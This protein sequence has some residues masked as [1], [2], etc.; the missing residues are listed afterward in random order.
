MA[1]GPGRRP[2]LAQDVGWNLPVYQPRETTP[3]IPHGAQRYQRRVYLAVNNWSGADWLICSD[4]SVTLEADSERVTVEIGPQ[5]LLLAYG[6]GAR[7]LIDRFGS[8]VTIRP[9][10]WDKGIAIVD[11]LGRRPRPGANRCA[12][13]PRVRADRHLARRAAEPPRHGRCCSAGQ[14]LTSQ[15]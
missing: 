7:V 6:D 11:W 14:A 10:A 2:A 15:R 5:S 4:H 13:R 8:A 3:P 12:A 9:T 1:L